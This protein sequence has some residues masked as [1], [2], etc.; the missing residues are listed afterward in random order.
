MTIAINHLRSEDFCG[1][2][3][4]RL[5]ATVVQE[6]PSRSLA[7]VEDAQL[8]D[9]QMLLQGQVFE[10]RPHVRLITIESDSVLIDNYGTLE[11]LPLEPGGLQF[12]AESSHDE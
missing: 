11:R 1:Q 3:P 7:R 12:T 5:N 8:S 9:A 6:D 4:L 2:L 10:G